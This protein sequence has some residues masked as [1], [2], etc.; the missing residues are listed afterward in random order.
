MMNDDCVTIAQVLRD[1]GYHT[2]MTGKWHL[3]LH[4]KES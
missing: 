2:L 1:A 3:G 4:R